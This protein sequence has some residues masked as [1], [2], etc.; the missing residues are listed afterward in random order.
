ML[1]D[2]IGLALATNRIA[3]NYYNLGDYDKSIDYNKHCITLSD[4]E[5]AFAGF[6]NI[7]ICF[8]KVENYSECIYNFKKALDWAR[9]RD[10]KIINL[11]NCKK[12]F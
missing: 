1:E 3:I 4:I 12:I 8:R 11:Y 9:S 10:V 5:N 6:Y 7:G 2:K